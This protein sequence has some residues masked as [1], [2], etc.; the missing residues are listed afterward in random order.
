MHPL[1]ADVQLA[2]SLPQLCCAFP[3]VSEMA[4]FPAFPEKPP[5][6]TRAELPQ[7]LAMFLPSLNSTCANALCHS[8]VQCAVLSSGFLYVSVM[9]QIL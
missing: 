7:H 1:S 8:Q 6:S 2:S 5:L 9:S 4:P 3:R